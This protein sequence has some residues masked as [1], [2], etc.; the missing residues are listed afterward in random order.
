MPSSSS[1]VL[2]TAIAVGVAGALCWVGLSFEP[3]RGERVAWPSVAGTSFPKTVHHADG[4]DFVLPQP[5]VRVLIASTTLVD[6]LTGLLPRE[7]VAA[8]CAQ[9]STVSTLALGATAWRDLPTYDRFATEIVLG[10][11][12]D[13]VLCNGYNDPQTTTALQRVGVPVV[14]L[15]GPAS[16]ADCRRSVSLLGQ[17]L[18]I[19]ADAARL[20]ADIDRRVTA[21]QER[22]GNRPWRSALCF[23]HNP[24]G[25]WTGG[26]GTLHDEAL[27][28]AG[29]ENAAARRGLRGHGQVTVEEILAMNPDLL[30]V[31]APVGEGRGSLRFL[32]ENATLAALPALASGRVVELHPALYSAGSH[33]VL[34]AAEAI[35]AARR[36]FFP[37]TKR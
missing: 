20:V 4:A 32:R 34:D 10:F 30:V 8:V 11:R 18:G 9:A 17:V 31:D 14:V 13:L 35:A 15:P 1:R 5:P 33:L 23:T 3:A 36:R 7:R 24:T 21:L 27:R 28:L 22:A 12:P 6:F 2:Q 25:S 19:E 37:E 26:S 29:L 16:I